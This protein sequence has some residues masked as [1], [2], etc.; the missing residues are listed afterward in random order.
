MERESGVMSQPPS[1]ELGQPPTCSINPAQSL[2][3]DDQGQEQEPAMDHQPAENKVTSSEDPSPEGKKEKIH[4]DP[5]VE[6]EG[7]QVE[8]LWSSTSEDAAPAME[9]PGKPRK[10]EKG[11]DVTTGKTPET[12]V[13]GS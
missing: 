4:P 5:R 10:T 9:A 11:P 1:L 3:Q 6:W 7:H 2:S 12:G 13:S 8:I